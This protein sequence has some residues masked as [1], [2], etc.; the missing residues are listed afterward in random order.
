VGPELS[1]VPEVFSNDHVMGDTTCPY[2]YVI[3]TDLAFVFSGPAKVSN[4]LLRRICTSLPTK[5]D[6]AVDMARS[7]MKRWLGTTLK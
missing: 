4:S 7:A 2:C 1:G 6:I 3:A 5:E